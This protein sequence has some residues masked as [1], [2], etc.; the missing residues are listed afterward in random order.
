MIR[1][2]R[3]IGWLL[4]LLAVLLA[5][6]SGSDGGEETP[7][8]MLSI[9]VYAPEHPV[10][11]RG[12]EGVTA[13]GSSEENKIQKLQIW[14]F[15]TGTEEL[16][17]Y[18][19]MNGDQLANLNSSQHQ[20]VFRMEIP[21]SFASTPSDQRSKVDVYVLANVTDDNCGDSKGEGAHRANPAEGSL[22]STHIVGNY[23]CPQ[24][25]IPD[26]GIPMSAVLRQITVD[27]E[28]PVLRITTATLVRAVSK[29]RFVFSS[30]TSKGDVSIEGVELDG[31]QIPV[32]DYMFKE[33]V[34]ANYRTE[35]VMMLRN[36]GII[37]KND[38]PESYE[39][40][41]DIAGFVEALDKG[42]SEDKL[43][44]SSVFL[45]PTDKLL[46]GKIYY[47]VGTDVSQRSARFE[48][49]AKGDFS[50]NHTWIIYGFFRANQLEVETVDITPWEDTGSE[51]R[52][53]YNW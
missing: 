31:G 47:R 17:G 49:S 6:C 34:E 40:K 20:E 7:K 37:N 52:E 48:M 10:V 43:S 13:E 22:E 8:P 3:H 19:G 23:F 45:R 5:G 42:V 44:E 46:K 9:Y 35:T 36:M 12:V 38:N 15:K 41:D 50:R 53:V 28:S 26:D 18:L 11:T 14:I 32:I 30:H 29:I 33:G 51:E 4:S 16:I 39:Y 27:G 24:E 1:D 2:K 25:G 21:E